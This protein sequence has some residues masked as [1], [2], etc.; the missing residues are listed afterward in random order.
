[1]KVILKE[2]VASLGKRGDTVKVSDGYARNYLIPKGLAL[3]A[4]GKNINVLEHTK[5]VIAQ[6]SEKERKKAESMVQQFSGV[7]VKIPCKVGE[8]DKLFGSVTGKD[9]EKALVEKG[10]EVDKRQIVIEDPI[11]SLGEHRVKVK[12]YPGIFADIAVTVTRQE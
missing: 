11:K 1:M 12:L 4:T 2:D 7:T 5:K 9:I 10:F 6:Q 3:E 8:M